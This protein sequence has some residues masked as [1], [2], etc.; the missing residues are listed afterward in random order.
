MNRITKITCE[1]MRP[2]YERWDKAVRLTEIESQVV[3]L[4]Y[5][6]RRSIVYMQ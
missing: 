2:I 1:T 6:E 3:W 4:R 5:F